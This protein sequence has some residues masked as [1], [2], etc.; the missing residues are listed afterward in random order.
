MEKLFHL[1]QAQ[2]RP[3][4][5]MLLKQPGLAGSDLFSLAQIPGFE[6]CFH[7]PDEGYGRLWRDFQWFTQ[8]VGNIAGP[9]GC[10]E[11]PATTLGR[12]QSPLAAAVPLPGSTD[13]T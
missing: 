4:R 13:C 5:Q 11:A 3:A 2:L 10:F 6:K 1:V 7:I 8:H 9:A 12:A